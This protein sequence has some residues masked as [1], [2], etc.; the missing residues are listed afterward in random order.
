MIDPREVLRKIDKSLGLTPMTPNDR[1]RHIEAL[2]DTLP[3]SYSARKYANGTTV[4]VVTDGFEEHIC[5]I[6]LAEEDQD[7]IAT[8]AKL[9]GVEVKRTVKPEHQASDEMLRKVF[10]K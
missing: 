10:G 2:C 9:A 6:G 5:V 3:I 7:I 8:V 4:S 1:L